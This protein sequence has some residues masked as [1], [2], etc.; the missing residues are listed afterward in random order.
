[1]T[2]TSLAEAFACLPPADLQAGRQSR[3]HGVAR[4]PSPHRH[5]L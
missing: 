2:R 4:L 1:L 3:R 5:P